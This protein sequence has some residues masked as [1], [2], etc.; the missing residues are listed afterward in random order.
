[1]IAVAD[2]QVH[3]EWTA[4]QLLIAFGLWRALASPWPDEGQAEYEIDVPS[5]VP[6]DV[7]PLARGAVAGASRVS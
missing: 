6:G 7:S 1:M 3:G 5:G 4:D 2:A